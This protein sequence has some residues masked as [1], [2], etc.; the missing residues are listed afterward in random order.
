MF[1]LVQDIHFNIINQEDVEFGSIA[2]DLD[3]DLGYK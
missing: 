2:N 3:K 1:K